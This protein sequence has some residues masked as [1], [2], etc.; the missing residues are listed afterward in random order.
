MARPRVRALVSESLRTP[1]RA[2]FTVHFVA[3]LT[4]RPLALVAEWL[5]QA[6]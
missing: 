5:K 6:A 3:V 4:T 1:G 2:K